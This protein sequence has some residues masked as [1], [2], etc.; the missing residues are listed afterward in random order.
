LLA[1]AAGEPDFGTGPGTL[2]DIEAKEEEERDAA[3]KAAEE[4]IEAN[5]EKR[6]LGGGDKSYFRRHDTTSRV[7]ADWDNEDTDLKTYSIDDQPHAK[8]GESDLVGP[9]MPMYLRTTHKP[10]ESK[11]AHLTADQTAD[12]AYLTKDGEYA[13]RPQLKSADVEKAHQEAAAKAAAQATVTVEDVP[14]E[15]GERVVDI[16]EDAQGGA[17]KETLAGLEPESKPRPAAAAKPPPQPAPPEEK[18]VV[19]ANP[20]MGK[21][22]VLGVG[23][24]IQD[25]KHKIW[26]ASVH[27]PY[28]FRGPEDRAAG[29][30]Q[31]DQM[32]LQQN[33]APKGWSAPPEGEAT[34]NSDANCCVM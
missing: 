1:Q 23:K 26:V 28:S 17:G 32:N 33:G 4:E 2:V 20:F 29:G 12:Q 10:R 13:E 16:T 22:L 34:V 14:E 18:K 31:S 5:K 11:Y 21:T 30:G 6:G 15:D 9:Q 19:K 3:L 7:H 25:E 8:G 24:R 27:D